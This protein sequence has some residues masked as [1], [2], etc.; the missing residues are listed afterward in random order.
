[1]GASIIQIHG[2]I[3]VR[4]MSRL[5][6]INPNFTVIKSL[7]VKQENRDALLSAVERWAPWVDVFITDPYD[8]L[9]G[10]SGATGKTHD[11]EVS[12]VLVARS[13]KPVILAGGLNPD[14]VAPAIRAVRPW[15]GIVIPASRVVAGEK[16]MVLFGPLSSTHRRRFRSGSVK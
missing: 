12:R 8:P 5:R 9:T 15:G 3:P 4:E 14:N 11:W 6:K 10:A 7:I 13:L 2:D 1:V 16:I